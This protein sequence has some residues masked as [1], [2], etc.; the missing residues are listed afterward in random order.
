MIYTEEI[1]ASNLLNLLQKRFI[2]HICP[3]DCMAA[4]YKEKLT[5]SDLK[6]PCKICNRFIGLEGI[7]CPCTRLGPHEA[8]K[9]TWIAL[10][11]KGYL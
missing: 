3:I 1:H 8:R 6:Q 5:L 2:I 7:R 10:D 11:E 9:L 4:R